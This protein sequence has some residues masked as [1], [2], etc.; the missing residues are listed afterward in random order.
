MPDGGGVTGISSGTAVQPRRYRPRLVSPLLRR[1]VPTLNFLQLMHESKDPTIY[2]TLAENAAAV[3]G[4]VFATLGVIGS[5]WLGWPHA[6]AIASLAIGALLVAVA[7]YLASETRS[8][9]TGETASEPVLA[10][11]RRVFDSDKRVSAVCEIQ[12]MHLGPQDILVAA[13]LDFRDDLAR[14]RRARRVGQRRRGALSCEPPRDRGP[15]A[16]RTARHDG[17]LAAQKVRPGHGINSL[18]ALSVSVLD[19]SFQN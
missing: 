6:D 5:T 10:E 15:D 8:L 9:L 2:E 4:L 14:R 17:A 13:T 7:A 3:L 1:I 12:S 18:L 19:C 16:A 11:I